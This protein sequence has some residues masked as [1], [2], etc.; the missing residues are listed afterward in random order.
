MSTSLQRCQCLL[1]LVEDLLLTVEEQ[2]LV[3]LTLFY[4]RKAISLN[5]KKS[6]PLTL[7]FWKQLVNISLSLYKDT[8]TNRGCRRKYAKV[9]AKWLAEPNIG[10][11]TST[12][13]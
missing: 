8:Y 3:N 1:G 10:L 2:T 5:W 4:A 6:T 12:S 11:D 7:S 13:S 9:W